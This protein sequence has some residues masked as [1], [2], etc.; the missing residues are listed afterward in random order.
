MAVTGFWYVRQVSDAEVAALRPGLD[1][2]LARV[3]ADDG[4]QEAMATWRTW[5]ERVFGL[6]GQRQL[7]RLN[8][9]FLGAFLAGHPG[10]DLFYSCSRDD[11][12]HVTWEVGR[13]PSPYP[14]EALFAWTA[15]F[16][17]ASLL[18]VGL[19]PAR[20][21]RLPG[22]LGVFLLDSVELEQRADAIRHAHAI[23]PAERVDA[24]RRMNRWLE[25][26]DAAG[27]ATAH[28]IEAL[29][30]VVGSAVTAG[31]GLVSVTAML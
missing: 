31:V 8:R 29:P 11:L 30:L 19:G 27:F 18:Y 3:A 23:A 25:V 14:C 1:E 10:A 16:P 4:I 6:D 24:I 2:F 22:E 26:G 9:T 13:A 12:D 28:V 7:D 5:P 15:R 20:I 21:A 17:P